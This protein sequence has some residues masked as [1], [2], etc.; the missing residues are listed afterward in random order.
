MNQYNILLGVDAMGNE[1]YYKY[2]PYETRHILTQGITRS[3]K[4]NLI[5]GITY[6]FLEIPVDVR[7]NIVIIDHEA[8]F[9]RMRKKNP[10][11]IIFGEGGEMPLV[12]QQARDLGKLVRT[13]RLDVIIRIA[14]IF[15]EDDRFN[16]LTEFI[17]GMLDADQQHW[18][19]TL[20]VCDEIQMFANSKVRTPSKSALMFLIQTGLKRGILCLLA[21]QGVKDLYS[22][23]RKQCSNRIVGYTDDKEDCEL[24]C[25]E[26]LSMPK[27]DYDKIRKL[28]DV[29]GQFYARGIDI[30]KNTVMFR[31]K[32]MGWKT[33]EEKYLEVPVISKTGAKQAEQLRK[34]FATKPMSD[35][36]RYQSEIARLTL[37]IGNLKLNQMTEDN[38]QAYMRAGYLKGWDEKDQDDRIVINDLL[39]KFNSKRLPFGK[40]EIVYIKESDSPRGK[41]LSLT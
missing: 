20:F 14:S 21:T 38:I 17:H 23:I 16:F 32:D 1:I 11:F 40:I 5:E 8:E 31:S 37:E 12:L 24:I 33:R 13:E 39:N 4:S 19:N 29:R 28:G 27:S 15:D 6:G 30:S 18:L 25:D 3:G 36:A 34:I 10:N 41:V 26:L 22:D 7:P 2:K 35:D 9:G